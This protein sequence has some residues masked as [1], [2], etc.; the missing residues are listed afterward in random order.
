MF[1]SHGKGEG[2]KRG[3][4]H[5]H[6]SLSKAVGLRDLTAWTWTFSLPHV[7]STFRGCTAA[8]QVWGLWTL[9]AEV[10]GTATLRLQSQVFVFISARINSLSRLFGDQVQLLAVSGILDVFKLF[11][12]AAQLKFCFF[13]TPPPPP[14]SQTCMAAWPLTIHLGN[15]QSQITNYC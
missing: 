12:K 5:S 1:Y 9:P 2:K 7:G 6:A 14:L 13:R 10:S 3:E 4:L 8:E 11:H 15:T